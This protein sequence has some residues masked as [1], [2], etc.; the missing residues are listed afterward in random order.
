MLGYVYQY[1]DHLGNVRLSYSDA[2]KNG[3]ITQSEIIEESNYYPF[4]LKHKGYN[5]V[6]SSNG[7]STA[8]KFKYN[9]KEFEESLG[10]NLYE[11]DVRS[12]DPAIGRFTSID[13]LTHYDFSTYTAFDNNPIFWADPSGADSWTYISNG[14]YRNNQTGETSD[15]WQRAISETQSHFENWIPDGN[16]GF[17][18]EK[19]DGAE[20]LAQD[21]GISRK[22]AYSLMESQGYG[23]YVDSD[24]VTKSRINPNQVVQVDDLTQELNNVLISTN[25]DAMLI[26]GNTWTSGAPQFSSNGQAYQFDVADLKVAIAILTSEGNSV[27]K[28]VIR[29]RLQS[30]LNGSPTPL[31]KKTYYLWYGHTVGNLK[32]TDSYIMMADMVTSFSNPNSSKSRSFSPGVTQRTTPTI[33][34]KGVSRKIHT[35]PRGGKYYINSNGNKSY[36]KK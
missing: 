9:G 19:G 3:S 20:T 28:Q 15:D 14:N 23:T 30:G 13:P 21:T 1:K 2:N 27:L 34:V 35:G 32:L 11:M 29:K 10:L 4:G 26:Y 24:G 7:N 36:I 31:S 6:T 17:I 16:G 25:S 8:Q 18:A 5:N 12:Y 33:V 22:K